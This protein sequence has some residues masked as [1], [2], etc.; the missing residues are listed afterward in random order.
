MTDHTPF[1]SS[2]FLFVRHGESDANKKNMFAGSLDVELTQKG[3]DQAKEA[4]RHLAGEPIGSVFASPMSRTWKTA[5]IIAEALGG[6]AVEPIQ[7]ITERCYGDWEG[8]SNVGMDRSQTP[9]GGESPAE[10][11][12]RTVSAL[13]QVSGKPTILLIAHSGTFRAL[14]D[15]LL[16]HAVYDSVKNGRPIAFL[17]P[18]TAADPWRFQIMGL[19]EKDSL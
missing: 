7:G 10:F 16:G 8:R 4:A 9:P 18:E 12:E 11:N 14:H 3:I 13:K 1:F 19:Q 2:R 17:P 15:F 5:E 6:L